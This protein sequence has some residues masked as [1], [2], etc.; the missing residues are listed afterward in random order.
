VPRVR[1][2]GVAV[3]A[4]ARKQV[5]RRALA[6]ACVALFQSACVDYVPFRPQDPPG[7]SSVVVT[8]KN[9][10][11][12]RFDPP[13]AVDRDGEILVFHGAARQVLRVSERDIAKVEASKAVNAIS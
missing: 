3:R 7:E 2:E 10:D 12:E 8:L 1:A 4:E 13:V 11:V 9:G 5:L 6:V